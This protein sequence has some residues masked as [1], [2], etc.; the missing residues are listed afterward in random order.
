MQNV[1]NP[2]NVVLA[3][4]L[5]AA[6][7]L[8][9]RLWTKRRGQQ[10]GKA[11]RWE[12]Y[13]E[14]PGKTSAECRRLLGARSADDVMA[15]E[16]EG[17][18]SGGWYIHFVRHNATNQMLD[19]LFLIQFEA[20]LPARF[21]LRFVREAFGMREPVTPPELLD[22]FFGGKLG[23]RRIQRTDLEAFSPPPPDA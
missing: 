20:E 21:S 3:V 8:A 12:L 9:A 2:G 10:G 17:A 5:V 4:V 16:L 7:L 15:Y 22:A 6:V 1:I 14:A 19:T 23:A 11:R 18:Q 13:Y